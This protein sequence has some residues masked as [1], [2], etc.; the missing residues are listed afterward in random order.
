MYVHGFGDGKKNI[1][2]LNQQWRKL[3]YGSLSICV[4]RDAAEV[5]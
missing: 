5:M 4:A 1:L 2:R 3:I